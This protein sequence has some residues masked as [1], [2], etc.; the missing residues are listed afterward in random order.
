[1]TMR[2]AFTLLMVA[3]ATVL[4]VTSVALAQT[5]PW[6]NPGS[7]QSPPQT[8]ATRRS[9]P[10]PKRDLSGIW[11]AGFAG[12]AP[13]GQKTVAPLTAL[14]S[15]VG[16]TRRSGDGSRTAPVAQINDP[17]STLGDPAGFPRDLLFELRPFQIVQTANQVLVLHMFEK[18]WRVIWTDGRALP[19]DPDPRWYG[20]SVGK[21][22]DD[23]TF[24]VTTIGTDERTWLN[25][26]GDPHSNDLT[27]EERYHRVSGGTLELTVLITDP[28]MY[29]KP[30][31][32]RDKLSLS[33]MPADTDLMEMIPS[34]SEAAEYRRIMTPVRK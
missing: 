31:L 29:T 34:A 5:L 9:T 1:M 28:K 20:Y 17:L 19:K 32:G 26:S 30:W 16:G 6:N 21:W 13:A 15:R 2:N 14:G 33:L 8:P 10:A 23:Y 3:S 22:V 11:D 25:N 4:I 7:E 12:V 18:R 24:V 27:V